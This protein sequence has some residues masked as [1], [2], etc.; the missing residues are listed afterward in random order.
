MAR[1]WIGILLSLAGSAHAQQI[2]LV[3]P[4]HS[5]TMAGRVLFA[6][7]DV[8]GL[9]KDGLA[10]RLAQGDV[11][12]E[13][14]L[15]RTG[16][17]SHVQLRMSDDALLALRPDSR[18]RLHAYRFVEQDEQ[19]GRASIEVLIGGLRSI[20]G[21]I[22]RTEKQNYIIRGGKALIGVRGT[23]HET[24]V[25][26]GVGTYN[27]VTAGGTYLESAG[28][29]V[30]L[31]PAETGFAGVADA[32]PSRLARAPE[33][34]HAAFE[35]NAAAFSPALRADGLGDERRLQGG[36]KLGH[37]RQGGKPSA[38]LPPPALGEN[39]H[40]GLGKGGRCGGPCNDLKKIK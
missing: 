10:R 15:I 36:P 38:V 24:F 7:G 12:R 13:G 26:A 21:A 31:D 30:D 35:Q 25:V 17:E 28:R 11:V 16:P 2:A 19:S 29:R 22:G 40:H 18:V 39:A 5:P 14:E 33:F 27:R 4:A 32:V 6:T 37:D 1:Y 23:D 20:T 34:M 9:D 3:A 8:Q